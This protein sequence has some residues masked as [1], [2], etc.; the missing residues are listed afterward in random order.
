MEGVDALVG[1]NNTHCKSRNMVS[2]PLNLEKRAGIVLTDEVRNVSM[3]LTAMINI[4]RDRF[5]RVKEQRFL[6]SLQFRCSELYCAWTQTKPHGHKFYHC[7]N[8]NLEI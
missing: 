2:K 8:T 6:S 7:C 3:A 5:R 1:G 4:A